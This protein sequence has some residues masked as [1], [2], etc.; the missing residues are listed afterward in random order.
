[1]FHYF[2]RTPLVYSDYQKNRNPFVDHPEWV[3]AIYAPSE[4][5]C[6]LSNPKAVDGVIATPGS[7]PVLVQSFHFDVELA[8]PGK[9]VILKSTDLVSWAEVKQAVS[10][11]L[12][13]GFPRDEPRCFFKVMQPQD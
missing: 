1:M 13:V 9:F 6:R 10:G 7:P 8:H 4:S 2:W 3:A 12:H 5:Q 11:I